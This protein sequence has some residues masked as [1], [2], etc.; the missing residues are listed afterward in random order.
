ML[1]VSCFPDLT[2]E[3]LYSYLKDSPDSRYI[4]LAKRLSYDTTSLL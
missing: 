4:V 3:Q 2:S 1:L